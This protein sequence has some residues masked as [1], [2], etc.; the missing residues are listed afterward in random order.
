MRKLKSR[1]TAADP[2]SGVP[3]R[4]HAGSVG[5]PP[6]GGLRRY[7]RPHLPAL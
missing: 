7:R 4:C 1:D 3:V 2:L 5:H 6:G